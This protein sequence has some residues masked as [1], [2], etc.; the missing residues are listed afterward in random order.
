[1]K[2]LKIIKVKKTD[3]INDGLKKVLK[4][5]SKMASKLQAY[6]VGAGY[7]QKVLK[8]KKLEKEFSQLAETMKKVVMKVD[9]LIKSYMNFN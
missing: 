5:S 3:E 7:G 1:M 2:L 6:F 4:D 9:K 8:D